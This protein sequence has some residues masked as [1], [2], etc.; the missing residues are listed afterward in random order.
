MNKD[1]AKVTIPHI[2]Y[3]PVLNGKHSNLMCD[4][5]FYEHYFPVDK[6]S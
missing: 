6:E 4:L 3:I 5:P 2:E 1:S